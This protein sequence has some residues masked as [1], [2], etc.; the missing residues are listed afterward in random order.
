VTTTPAWQG[1][2][3]GSLPYYQGANGEYYYG[4]APSAP[5]VPTSYV[6]PPYYQGDA[7]TY[8]APYVPASSGDQSYNTALYSKIKAPDSYSDYP[9]TTP[10]WSEEYE[11]TTAK[12]YSLPQFI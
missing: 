10:A 4:Q 11:T 3:S 12:S 1:D 8:Y 6:S 5:S 9:A 2:D 7:S